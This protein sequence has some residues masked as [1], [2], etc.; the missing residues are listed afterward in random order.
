MKNNYK[1]D[2]DNE[3]KLAMQELPENPYRGFNVAFALMSIIPLLGVIYLLVVR[4]STFDILAG[5]VGIVLFL[6]I[7]ISLGG[8]FTGYKIM[9]TV[10][11][12]T[13]F[14]ATRAKKSDT[15]KSTLLATVSHDLKNPLFILSANI[16]M[17]LEGIR[18]QVTEKQSTSLKECQDVIDRMGVLVNNLLDC[19]KVEA[20]LTKIDKKRCDLQELLEKQV[21]EQEVLRQKKEISLNKEF[22]KGNFSV[23]GDRDKLTQAINNLLSNAIKYTPEKG[24]VT[25]KLSPSDEFVKME[26]SDTG[27]GIPRDRLENIFNKFE[28]I[29]E[30]EE[31]SGLGLAITKDIVELHRG[32]IW[33]ESQ[34]GKGSNFIVVLPRS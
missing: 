12:K 1:A 24:S 33:A 2:I 3:L 10:L 30:V 23:W 5:D 34:E 27:E 16:E 15:L 4:V 31:G 9:K 21:K 8:L 29:K 7:L 22:S 14:H 19:Y 17:I 28:R 13:V 18:G 26:F 20:G 25:L 32:R 11:G 6:F